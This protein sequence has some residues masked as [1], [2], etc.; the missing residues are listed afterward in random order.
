VARLRTE[1]D[2]NKVLRSQNLVLEQQ[3]VETRAARAESRAVDVQILRL[4]SG[5][6]GSNYVDFNMRLVNY[7]KRQTECHV[8]ARVTGKAAA[9][10]PEMLDLIPNQP[11]ALVRVSVPRP[12]LADLMPGC[13]NEITLYGET[14]EV[15][16]ADSDG[17]VLVETTWR[18]RIYDPQT[19]PEH[20]EIQQRYWRMGRGE[21]TE[22]D[23]RAE[24]LA[25]R[26]RGIENP[27]NGPDYEWR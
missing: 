7:G 22:A 4:T 10:Q 19:D 8:A 26:L 14:L 12:Q 23:R 9:C 2:W 17:R 11:P 3:L 6:G 20:H 13:N 15:R 21:E 18:E 27:E 24:H 25:E 16:I 1:R 5:G